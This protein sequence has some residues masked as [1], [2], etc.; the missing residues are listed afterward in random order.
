[1]FF[2]PS[3]DALLKI[4]RDKMKTK[5]LI[6]ILL[7]LGLI[8]TENSWGA[9]FDATGI[10]NYSTSNSWS[11]YCYPTSD[12]QGAVEIAQ[13]GNS[14]TILIDGLIYSGSVSNATY[15]IYRSYYE[16]GGWTTETYT[17]VLSTETTGIGHVKWSWTDG[18]YVCNGGSAIA[19]SKQTPT[20]PAYKA[21]GVWQVTTANNYSNCNEGP[22]APVT[23]ITSVIQND[24]T[25]TYVTGYGIHTGRISG[26]NYAAQ[27]SYFEDGGITTHTVRF[28]LTSASSGFGSV[29]WV[30]ADDY[31]SC[32]GGN[33]FTL[34]KLP[35]TTAFDAN[36][37][38]D[39]TTTDYWSNCSG[40]PST[41][42][43]GVI[44]ITQEN[45]EFRFSGYRN[46]QSGLVSGN[47]Y[48]SQV[49]YP[50][51]NGTIIESTRFNLTSDTQGSGNT[52]WIWTD[53]FYLCYGGN[54]IRLT[55][56]VTVNN[57][58]LKPG[59][60]YPGNNSTQISLTPILKTGHFTD[61]DTDDSHRLTEWEISTSQDFSS[62]VF[63]IT[64]PDYLTSIKVPNHVLTTGNTY[65]L[66]T[67]FYD[68]RHLASTWSETLKFSTI[69]AS[70]DINNNGIPDDQEDNTLDM[71]G[72]NIKDNLQDD[73]KS[74]KVGDKGFVGVSRKEDIT[75][76]DINAIEA[77][78]PNSI[79]S[80]LRPYSMPMDM[81]VM[82]LS[83]S[84][85]TD[86]CEIK[87]HYSET[88]PKGVKWLMYDSVSGWRDH[89][90]QVKFSGNTAIVKLKDWGYG[91]ADGL[92]NG[93]IVDPG[94]FGYA[95]FIKG[96]ITDSDTNQPLESA[97]VT[98]VG[99]TIPVQTDGNYFSPII[100]GTYT[101][102]VSA[103]G[104]A[105]KSAPDV[106]I[107][108]GDIKTLSFKLQPE[109]KPNSDH[110][111]MDAIIIQQFLTI[112]PPAGDLPA[113]IN[114]NNDNKA[115][116]EE[117]SYILQK[118]SGLR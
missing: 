43:A 28:T 112:K 93:N 88:I 64:S 40:Q 63:A 21:T 50:Y 1:M 66:R 36:G 77:I 41:D 107:G 30:W 4:K 45:I 71:D 37:N 25:F 113:N 11:D 57:A 12:R 51:S 60:T 91:D 5:E 76:L 35:D 59:F 102:S 34:I 22:E 33:T 99:E 84:K 69:T 6:S 75:V 32:S 96:Q 108:Q 101:I 105:M 95:S 117:A 73:I 52:L 110:K 100:P 7:F 83:V 16:D 81:V 68:S 61:L 89:T 2:E 47:E 86:S 44:G 118:L 18:F 98:V 17:F 14:I 80:V 116:L 97:V 56:A 85:P 49:S 65:Y 8:F 103:S 46:T 31:S 115:G 114:I 79:S 106:T 62:I 92:P 90:A 13:N 10:W 87:L 24:D 39:F 9:T 94:G 20:A 42:T 70:N 111:L 29:V 48:T 26:A 104:Y 3:D 78:D 38:W 53:G 109:S 67:R 58:P 15:T 74:L 54:S 23:G 19:M 55:K 27:V 72:D 82:D